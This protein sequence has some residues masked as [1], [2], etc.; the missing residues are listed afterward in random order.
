M[1]VERPEPNNAKP[2]SGSGPP[3]S[4]WS[5]ILEHEL[6]RSCAAHLDRVVV[7]GDT[8]STQDALRKEATPEERVLMLASR[9]TAGRGRLGRQWADTGAQGVSMS[10][11]LQLT[12]E[13]QRYISLLAAVATAGTIESA[14]ATAASP[15]N[16]SGCDRVRI[17]W[18][19]DIML[20][21][22]SAAHH[23][24]ALD[25]HS[26]DTHALAKV[27]GILIERTTSHTIICIGINV[28]QRD[29][30]WPHELRSA[31]ISLRQAGCAL[32]R[33]TVATLLMGS[34]CTWLDNT[35]DEIMRS[36]RTRDCLLGT[37][38]TFLY[39]NTRFRGRV[40]AIDPTATLTVA[41][42]SGTH[43]HL[44]AQATSLVHSGE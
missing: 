33:L 18:P 44:P 22:G 6:L 26:P 40:L 36:Y 14:L 15:R 31:A 21:T 27:A 24:H 13:H 42:E 25:T 30:D 39:D 4:Q 43:V 1:T 3:L 7:L 12:E 2:D 20:T 41:L 32:S 29:E 19:N 17:R 16:P 23:T 9:Q 38:Q 34:L 5:E 37:V 35:D 11:G 28:R 8:T 10:F